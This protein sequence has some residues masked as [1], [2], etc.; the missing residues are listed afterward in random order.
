MNLNGTGTFGSANVGTGIAVTST[1]TLSGEHAI[2]YSLT[3]PTG[4]TAN[5]SAVGLTITGISISNKVYNGNN[6]ATI[7]GTAAYSGL[8]NGET[9][10]VSGTPSATFADNEVGTGKSVTV[11]G[12]TA[13]S[14]NYS[15]TQPTGLSANI[16]AKGL[17]ITGIS[18]ANKVYDR[19]TTATI[20]GT[21]TFVGLENGETFSATGGSASFGTVSVGNSKPVT[22][23]GF[24]APSP[25]YTVTQPT[26]LTGNITAAALSVTGSTV[27]TKLYDRNA[28]ATITGATLNGDHRLPIERKAEA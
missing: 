17:T 2:N 28:T 27:T 6:T 8:V 9:F 11:S 20:T 16:T 12:Y 18:I 3:Q 1:S 25:N 19:S 4:L 5:I 23:T 15:L 7:S 22:V 13:P 21:P 26:G 24:T 14:G 10:S